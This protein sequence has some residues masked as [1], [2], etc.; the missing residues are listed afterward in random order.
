LSS[1]FQRL[2]FLLRWAVLAA[3]A[4]CGAAAV[5]AQ[6]GRWNARLDLLTHFAP[7]WLAGGVVCLVLGLVIQR[8]W[9]RPVSAVCAVAALAS[10]GSIMAV[11]LSRMGDTHNPPLP[12]APTLKIIEFNAWERNRDPVGVARWLAAEQ[13][14]VAII[15]EPPFNLAGEIERRTGM[16][17]FTGSGAM[18]ASRV[19]PLGTYQAWDARRLPG[20]NTDIVW[21]DL[22]APDGRP[23][24]VF[25]VHCAWPIPAS[26]AWGQDRKIAAIL[27]TRDRYRAILG[28]D[29]N[30]TQWSFRQRVA[31]GWFG[32]ERR[33]RAN[34]TYPARRRNSA[35]FP[36]AFLSIDHIYAGGAWR[37]VSLERGPRLGSD[38]YPLIVTLAWVADR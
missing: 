30:S 8:G 28:G 3:A 9:V 37:T 10:A 22:P 11:D 35:P 36:A 1:F 32:L 25:A 16:R 19:K 27:D 29:F 26:F 23:F 31:D 38:H 33:D 20:A 18:I 7:A 21:I 4:A 6:G 24:T 2:L 14:D 34:L 12:G 17:T 13:P 5:A 15:P